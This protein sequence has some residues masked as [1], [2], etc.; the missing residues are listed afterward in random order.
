[1]VRSKA[2]APYELEKY[3]DL[4]LNHLCH[5]RNLWFH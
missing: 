3:L 2:N 1:M 5:L 4:G